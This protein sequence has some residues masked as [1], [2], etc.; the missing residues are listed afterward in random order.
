MIIVVI[1]IEP[2]LLQPFEICW[3]LDVHANLFDYVGEGRGGGGG[4]MRRR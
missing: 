3:A 1:E 2:A 4:G